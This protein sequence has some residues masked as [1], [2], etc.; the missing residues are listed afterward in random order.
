MYDSDHKDVVGRWYNLDCAQ[1]ENFYGLNEFL[2]KETDSEYEYEG[3]TYW[4]LMILRFLLVF[5]FRFEMIRLEMK[6]E[7]I[8]HQIDIIILIFIKYLFS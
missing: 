4:S 1:Q 7:I 8:F 5:C 6:P 3:E 2:Y